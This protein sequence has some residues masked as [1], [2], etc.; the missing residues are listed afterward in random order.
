[1]IIALAGCQTTRQ[2]A[3]TGETE[4]NSA[5]TGA[6]GGC[7]V[8]AIAGAVINKEKGA[9]IGCGAGGAVG[10][11]VGNNLDEQEAALRE[12]LVHSGVQIKRT[13][14]KIELILSGDISFESG[15]TELSNSIKPSLKS[16]VK[17]MNEFDDTALI[18]SGYTDSVGSAE[19][20]KQLS[21]SR[22]M[23]VQQYLNINGLSYSRT[24]AQGYGEFSP[25]C[26]NE[27]EAGKRCNRR[28]ELTI[29][30]Q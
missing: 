17:V 5:T 12:E 7:V 24:K 16:I 14:E 11:A 30:K 22:A 23:A 2:N 20:N 29:V 8:G 18:I 1:M 9:L 27:T 25:R 15:K 6:V 3:M 13:D 19:Y 10:Y 28:V 21:E 4:T 26:S